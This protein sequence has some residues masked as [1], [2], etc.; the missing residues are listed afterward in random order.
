[1]TK[2]QK[3]W[4]AVFLAMF[5]VPE[6]LWS[7]ISSFYVSFFLPISGNFLQLLNLIP[8]PESPNIQ[9]LIL[10]IQFIGL[11]LTLL[12]INKKD[13]IKNK[14]VKWFSKFILSILIILVFYL[15]F[16]I[17]SFNPQIG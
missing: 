1:M 11:L 12:I 13:Y 16:F 17:F 6:I 5:L 14:V 4:L 2:K 10:I 3:I 8:N 15:L 9:K 7:P